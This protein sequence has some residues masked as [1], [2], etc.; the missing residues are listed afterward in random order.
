MALH[1]EVPSPVRWMVGA[2][3]LV[4]SALVGG[5]AYSA[6]QSPVETLT[7]I[8]LFVLGAVVPFAVGTVF[9]RFLEAY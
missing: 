9:L 2:V 3:I 6:V 1:E 8:G 5:L 7:F 4:I